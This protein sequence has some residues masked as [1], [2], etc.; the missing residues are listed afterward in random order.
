MD[1][2][3]R[4]LAGELVRLAAFA[5]GR[6]G[7][8]PAGVWIGDALPPDEEM[9]RIA[10]VVGYSETAF[11]QR[12]ADRTWKTR[13]FSPRAEVS[14]CGHA[15]VA[16]GVA[17]GQRFGAGTFRLETTVGGVPVDVGALPDGTMQAT[18][19]S[20]LPEHRPLPAGVVDQVLAALRWPPSAIDPTI[21]PGLA[22]AGAWHVI[23]PVAS[24]AR[25]AN[26]DYDVDRLRQVMQAHDVTTVQLVHRETNGVYNARNPFP[27]GGVI[28]DPATGA[29]AA[30]FGGYLRDLGLVTPPAA[31]LIRQGYD[32]GCPS[33]L[34]VDIPRSG[35]IR[36]TGA[37]V[38][39]RD[40]GGRV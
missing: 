39:I 28:E 35:G 20:V 18:L 33:H 31:I 26:L 4:E 25:L 29:S 9:Q 19:T 1:A 10:G 3:T 8:N 6:R 24:R 30:A 40:R 13:Y 38:P 7:G 27:V 37:A 15:T 22:Y 16:T 12:I 14:F 34:F 17:L 32:M 36:V 21:A 11:I 5:A 23:V 2:S